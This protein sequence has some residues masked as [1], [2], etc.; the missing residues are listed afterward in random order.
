MPTGSTWKTTKSTSE[1]RAPKGAQPP[2]AFGGLAVDT[3][4]V[5]VYASPMT[6]GCRFPRPCSGECCDERYKDI[7]ITLGKKV[8]K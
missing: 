3:V 6:S 8:K 1:G 2:K 5:R 7:T 4:Y